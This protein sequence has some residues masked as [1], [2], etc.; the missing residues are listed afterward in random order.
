MRVIVFSNKKGGVGK[1]TSALA[2]AAGLAKAGYKVLAIDMDG[3]GN[4]GASSGGEKN[5]KGT[6]LCPKVSFNAFRHAI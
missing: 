6:E 4:F 3:Q 5:V 1:T 2:T